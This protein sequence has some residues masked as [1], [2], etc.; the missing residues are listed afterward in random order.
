[1]SIQTEPVGAQARWDATFAK[2]DPS[3]PARRAD[4]VEVDHLRRLSRVGQSCAA[5]VGG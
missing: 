3:C 2:L 5:T 1:M 4:E